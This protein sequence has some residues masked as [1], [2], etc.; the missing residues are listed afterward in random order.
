ML[1][2][3]W[4]I[5]HASEAVVHVAMS[6]I[7]DQ[8]RSRLRK[9]RIRL[10]A[11]R[12]WLLKTSPCSFNTITPVQMRL[13][14]LWHLF[15]HCVAVIQLVLKPEYFS[16]RVG[17]LLW[18]C[19]ALSIACSCRGLFTVW[20]WL[21]DIRMYVKTNWVQVASA[22]L[23]HASACCTFAVKIDCQ[24]NEFHGAC[25]VLGSYRRMHLFFFFFAWDFP[26]KYECVRGKWML[27]VSE[28][29]R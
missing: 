18:S 22:Q 19:T 5:S 1:R 16:D 23:T 3:L 14:I 13:E 9:P 28:M 15:P 29:W 8:H 20:L 17:P 4:S 6:K 2:A 12:D 27:Y 21:C 24:G 26:G 11:C 7:S 25:Y 10:R